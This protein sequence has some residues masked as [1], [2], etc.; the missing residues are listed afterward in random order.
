MILLFVVQSKQDC[1]DN[2]LWR[3]LSGI[4]F[5]SFGM[6]GLQQ[7]FTVIFSYY[8]PKDARMEITE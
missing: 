1:G 6:V 4:F 5:A 8:A 7:H 2:T 3:S